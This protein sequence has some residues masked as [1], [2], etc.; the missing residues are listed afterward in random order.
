[1]TRLDLAELTSNLGNDG[2]VYANLTRPAPQGE[3]RP[4]NGCA[5]AARSLCVSAQKRSIPFNAN[6]VGFALFASED[7]PVQFLPASK[8]ALSEH[9]TAFA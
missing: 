8:K 6:L 4:H 7:S 2:A 3:R 9:G 5:V 1:V